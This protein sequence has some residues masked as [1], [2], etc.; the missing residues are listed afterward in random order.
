MKQRVKKASRSI[1][2]SLH[3]EKIITEMIIPQNSILSSN[4]S[5]FS[6]QVSIYSSS[7]SDDIK[8]LQYKNKKLSEIAFQ[9]N[10][11]ISS[12]EESL[13]E[14]QYRLN[15]V[16]QV[17]EKLM[18]LNEESKNE[19]KNEKTKIMAQLEKISQN[20]KIYSQSHQ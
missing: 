6:T 5:S 17:N 10:N 12:L 16:T 20:Y 4:S 13:Q 14:A 19:L 3:S 18:Q 15:E 2:K 1:P 9:A 8:T 7:K 11:K